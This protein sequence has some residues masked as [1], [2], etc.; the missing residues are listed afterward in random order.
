MCWCDI[1]VD[2]VIVQAASTRKKFV[3]Q[4]FGELRIKKAKS[5]RTAVA[6]VIVIAQ[7]ALEHHFVSSF[8]CSV[9]DN[10]L[11]L[12]EVGLNFLGILWG[13]FAVIINC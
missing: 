1:F 4:Y 12:L 2:Y 11:C 6:L 8:L 3:E 13:S 10:H 9:F 5:P 7:L